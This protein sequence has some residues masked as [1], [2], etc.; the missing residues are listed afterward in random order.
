MTT[1]TATKNKIWNP[2]VLL[3]YQ[4][5]SESSKIIAYACW[6]ESVVKNCFKFFL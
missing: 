4:C 3:R 2:S 5:R 1:Y 6:Y